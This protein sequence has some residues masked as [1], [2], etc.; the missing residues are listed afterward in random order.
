[1]LTPPQEK[2]HFANNSFLWAHSTSTRGLPS[3]TATATPGSAKSWCY[4]TQQ[5]CS[6]PNCS[7]ERGLA[8][9]CLSNVS[10][11]LRVFPGDPAHLLN[12]VVVYSQ[13]H[14]LF[15]MCFLICGRSLSK[16]RLQISYWTWLR[17]SS[18][19]PRP[20]AC[21]VLFKTGIFRATI[22]LSRNNKEHV[23]CI[24]WI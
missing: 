1:M 13:S 24:G 7:N 20:T 21:S 17:F 11:E 6:V 10:S 8:T 23:Y 18:P 4:W 22:S 2:S 15:I 16:K 12:S 3:Q 5:H 9:S 19:H 14:F